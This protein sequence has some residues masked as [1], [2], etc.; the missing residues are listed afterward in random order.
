MSLI[1]NTEIEYAEKEKRKITNRISMDNSS[2]SEQIVVLLLRNPT[3]NL[4]SCP[5]HR[6]NEN[7]CSN[8]VKETKIEQKYI[9]NIFIFYFYLLFK[10]L[11]KESLITKNKILFDLSLTKQKQ[12]QQE[13][14]HIVFISF[15]MFSFFIFNYFFFHLVCN[16]YLIEL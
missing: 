12:Q 3:K 7:N 5:W 14:C 10:Y 2:S 4:F 11:R 13:N 9:S 6:R 8:N 15:I 1:C 16:I